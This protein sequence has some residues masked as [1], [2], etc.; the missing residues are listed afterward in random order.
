MGMRNRHL[1]PSLVINPDRALME[2]KH[3]VVTQCTEAQKSSLRN[4]KMQGKSLLFRRR[5]CVK[6]HARSTFWAK[7][8]RGREKVRTSLFPSVFCNDFPDK[9]IAYKKCS[10]LVLRYR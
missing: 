10:M 1:L 3:A 5:R 8:R 7:R 2:F 4:V 9:I 6:P